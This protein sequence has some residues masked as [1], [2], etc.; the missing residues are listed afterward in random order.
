[1]IRAA[2]IANA[3]IAKCSSRSNQSRTTPWTSSGIAQKRQVASNSAETP[4]RHRNE[5]AMQGAVVRHCRALAVNPKEFEELVRESKFLYWFIS[6]HRDAA[7]PG[8]RPQIRY[9]AISGTCFAVQ[10]EV[11]SQLRLGCPWN[12]GVPANGPEGNE[13]GEQLDRTRCRVTLRWN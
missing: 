10:R 1:M 7:P 8:G 5:Q 9:G 3:L 12:D 4:C 11:H 2:D 6:G 13:Y